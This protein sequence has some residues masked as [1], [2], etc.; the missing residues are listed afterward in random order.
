MGVCWLTNIFN[1]IFSV[2]KMPNE[3]KSNTSISIYKNDV[4]ILN[5]TNYHGIK[6][7][8][9]TMNFGRE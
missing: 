9:H 3:W 7:I 6:L 4:N 1:K 5:Y 8:S 2:N